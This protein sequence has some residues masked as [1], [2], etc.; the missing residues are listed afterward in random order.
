MNDYAV[1]V[2]GPG[3]VRHVTRHRFPTSVERLDHG[4][5]EKS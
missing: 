5:F 4:F 3:R 2:I 1:I